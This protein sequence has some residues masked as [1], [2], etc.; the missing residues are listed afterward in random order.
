M[1]VAAY[2]GSRAQRQFLDDHFPGRGTKALSDIISLTD[3]R[4]L[5]L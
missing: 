1:P 4:V 5:I 3:R 2:M